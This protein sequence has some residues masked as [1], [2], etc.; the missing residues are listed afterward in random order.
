MWTTFREVKLGGYWLKHPR[1]QDGRDSNERKYRVK[2]SIKFDIVGKISQGNCEVQLPKQLHTRLRG[3]E[4]PE[5]GARKQEYF[6][7]RLA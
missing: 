6:H 3:N 2:D 4:D 5:R 7:Y 1:F